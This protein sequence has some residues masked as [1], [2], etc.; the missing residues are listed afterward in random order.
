MSK[1]R[2]VLQREYK[3][4]VKKKSF[5]L[6]SVISPFIIA[7]LVIAPILIQQSTFKQKTVLIVDN[8]LALGDLLE[9]NKSS[10]YIHYINMPIDATIEYVAS[11]YEN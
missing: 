9:K 7:G 6:L 8:T 1:L 3:T 10:K 4:R 2:L 5:L 11:R